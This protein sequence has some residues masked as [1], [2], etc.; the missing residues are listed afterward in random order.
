MP[1]RY[2]LE[3][4]QLDCYTASPNADVVGAV[5]IIIGFS[6]ASQLEKYT[7]GKGRAQ[8]YTHKNITSRTEFEFRKRQEARQTTELLGQY[9]DSPPNPKE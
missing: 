1:V 5:L 2:N 7:R 6:K 9:G 3:C 4:W 8:R